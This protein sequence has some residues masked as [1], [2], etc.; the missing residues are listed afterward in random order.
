MFACWFDVLGSVAQDRPPALPGYQGRS[1]TLSVPN[2]PLHPLLHGLVQ[3]LAAA[4]AYSGCLVSVLQKM[5]LLAD[6]V[7]TN[8]QKPGFRKTEDDL[9]SL[10][11]L[12][13]VTHE[14]LAMPRCE[15]AT[16]DPV[17][18]VGEMT[19]L[20]LLILLAG[21]K[22]KYGFIAVEAVG[23]QRK[24]ALLL[25]HPAIHNVPLPLGQIQIWLLL[26]TAML[27][28]P[29]QMRELY[30]TEITQ[31]MFTMDIVDGA[32]AIAISREILWMEIF[33]QDFELLA[34]EID[35]VVKGQNTTMN[36]H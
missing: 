31:R 15:H 34:H 8:F 1:T 9:T 26:T 6:F 21:L 16:L 5:D 17:E 3:K 24:F 20:G 28:P 27:Q 2:R 4:P 19:R 10:Q 32:S 30:L 7:N 14:L 33:T 11:I 25:E 22:A 18:I 12:G 36:A 29:G 23:L 35:I 13:P